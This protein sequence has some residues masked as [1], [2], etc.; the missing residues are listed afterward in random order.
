VVRQI[1]TDFVFVGTGERPDL[2][3]YGPLG[4]AA[5]ERGFVIADT[6]MRTSVSGVYAAGDL[7]GPPMEDVQGPQVRGRRGPQHHG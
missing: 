5:D 3:M 7:I 6:R 4:L 1:D 2:S